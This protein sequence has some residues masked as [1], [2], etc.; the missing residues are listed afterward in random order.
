MTLL[1]HSVDYE[2][3]TALQGGTEMGVASIAVLL[4]YGASPG[5]RGHQSKSALELAKEYG[6]VL[7]E[8]LLERFS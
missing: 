4:A 5:A 7:A 3:D 2:A 1:A 6:H 8:R